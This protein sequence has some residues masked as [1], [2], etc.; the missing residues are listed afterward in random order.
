MDTCHSIAIFAQLAN[1]DSL[2]QLENFQLKILFLCCQQDVHL[3]G[4]P[5]GRVSVNRIHLQPYLQRCLSTAWQICDLICV[6]FSFTC[7][8]ANFE[9][10]SS[11]AVTIEHV[12]IDHE[13]GNLPDALHSSL[14]ANINPCEYHDLLKE[15]LH[16]EFHNT[17]LVLHL[18]I[19]SLQAHFDEV[20]EFLSKFSHPPS[21]IFLTETR[22]YSNS[23]INVNIL[24]IPFFINLHQQ[25]LAE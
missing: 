8:S 16:Y 12:E 25:K 14:F 2:L 21:I 20:N 7:M 3:N 11:Q 5:V 15:D 4:Y 19:S 13:Q 9:I 22:I 6:C 1:F 18:N 23:T 24:V 10:S 17:F